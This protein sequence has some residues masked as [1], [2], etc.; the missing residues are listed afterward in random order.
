M[1][2]ARWL[3][4]AAPGLLAKLDGLDQMSTALGRKPT[5]ATSYESW[6]WKRTFASIV[7]QVDALRTWGAVPQITW[8]PWD[9]AALD[10]VNQPKYTLARIIA[11]D[12]DTYI[13]SWA[14]DIKTW[15]QPIR[16]RFAHEMNGTWYPW[17]EGVNGNKPYD[18]VKAWWHVRGIF[19]TLGVTNVQWIWCPQTP[20]PGLV[21]MARLYPGDA[22][23]DEV[24][25]DGYNWALN[26]QPWNSFYG[27]FKQGIAEVATFSTR[28]VSIGETGCPEAGGDKPAW[29]RDMWTQLAAWPQ[30]RGVLWFNM[31]KEADWRV[32]S[33]PASLTAFKAGL[34]AYLSS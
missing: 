17:C 11:G 20:Y 33:S 14:T 22:G 9:P 32:D 19:D 24:A 23:V 6:S 1:P 7:P 18:Y 15:G 21:S 4:A 3:G 29:I 26:G 2:E 31:N 28:P 12:F 27:V 25:L 5:V 13:R 8:E 16:I 34:P 10:K 30:V